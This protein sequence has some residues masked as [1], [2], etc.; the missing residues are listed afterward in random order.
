MCWPQATSGRD[1][2]EE[3]ERSQGTYFGSSGV[4]IDDDVLEIYRESFGHPNRLRSLGVPHGKKT[5]HP[6]IHGH[7]FPR[8]AKMRS[9]YFRYRSRIRPSKGIPRSIPHFP[10][11][12]VMDL[13]RYPKIK[14]HPWRWIKK[15]KYLGKAGTSPYLAWSKQPKVRLSRFASAYRPNSSFPLRVGRFSGSLKRKYRANLKPRRWRRW[16]R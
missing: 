12:A 6:R 11:P 9:R 16:K 10:S 13:K 15:S 1:S 14:L 3:D 2:H 7:R 4:C 8:R 5:R